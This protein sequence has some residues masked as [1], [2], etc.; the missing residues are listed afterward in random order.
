MY[1]IDPSPKKQ[2]HFCNAVQSPL[3]NN[4][5]FPTFIILKQYYFLLLVFV[6]FLTLSCVLEVFSLLENSPSQLGQWCPETA[7]GGHGIGK[8][9]K[10]AFLLPW[11]SLAHQVPH[12]SIFLL[13]W[14]HLYSLHSS[15]SV[16]EVYMCYIINI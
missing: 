14:C 2:Q 11:N 12:Y 16:H 10:Q 9:L 6:I 5:L 1:K 13:N 4:V 8:P 15:H 3:A 7:R